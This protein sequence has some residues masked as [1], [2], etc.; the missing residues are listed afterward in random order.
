M[1]KIY[2]SAA[3]GFKV[4]LSQAT[5]K[6]VTSSPDTSSHDTVDISSAARY[7]E[8]KSVDIEAE[9]LMQEIQAL[10]GKSSKL[11]DLIAMS[12]EERLKTAPAL[13]PELYK[14]CSNQAEMLFGGCNTKK[15]YKIGEFISAGSGAATIYFGMQMGFNFV[16]VMG[17]TIVISLASGILIP[18]LFH[19]GNKNN[20]LVTQKTDVYLQGRL[21][22][23]QTVTEGKL[24]SSRIKLEGLYEKL[25]KTTGRRP[26]DDPQA[27]Q[28]GTVELDLEDYVVIDGVKIS[29][30]KTDILS[31]P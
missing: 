13:F 23:E 8:K 30:K 4:D 11:R 19:R 15:D 7:I 28:N 26:D 22:L 2:F 29:R 3:S 27:K 14:E 10:Q 24:K 18:K 5:M 6:S 25:E 17:A 1:D 9:P 21:R 12:P 31:T 16:A 20:E